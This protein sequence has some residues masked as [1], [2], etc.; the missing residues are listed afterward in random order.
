MEHLKTVAYIGIGS[1]LGDKVK[2]C[3]EAIDTISNMSGCQLSRPSSFYRTEPIGMDGTPWF[4]NGVIEVKTSL[5]PYNLFKALEGIEKDMGRRRVNNLEPRIIDLDL[6]FYNHLAISTP[7]MVIP[8]PRLHL[9]RFVLVPLAEI[10]PYFIHPIYHVS[11][12]ELLKN[13]KD[14]NPVVEKLP[15]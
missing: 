3:I 10:A 1:N 8:H 9:R 4:I 13:L 12:R 11:V 6:L 5:T 7:H 14:G 2:N 15:S